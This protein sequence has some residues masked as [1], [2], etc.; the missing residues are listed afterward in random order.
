L[1]FILP[2]ITGCATN[3][4]KSLPG[5]EVPA[6]EVVQ[7]LKRL[8]DGLATD[9]QIFRV[10]IL[11]KG[12]TFRADGALV[13]RSPDTLQMSIFGP[14]FTTLWMQLLTRGDSIAVVLP[15]ENRVVRAVRSDTRQLG[16]MADSKGLTDGEFLGGVTGIYQ[17]ER[18]L[19][20]SMRTVATS[21]GG[22][23]RLRLFDD[24]SAYEFVYDKGLDAVVRFA[25]YRKGRLSREIIRSDF[26]EMQGMQ[27]PG[28]TVYRDYLA[29]REI[30]VFVSKEYI[31]LKL[32]DSSFEIMVPK[33]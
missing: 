6:E 30:I 16:E 10:R 15:K 33:D 13:Y 25:R 27:R 12:R 26:V 5:I 7:T 24:Q 4:Q 18:F 22:T 14:P 17:I 8:S 1:W 11:D 3:M 9:K 21:D 19:N 20:P 28:K 23:L 2:V 32:E 29:D 31:N